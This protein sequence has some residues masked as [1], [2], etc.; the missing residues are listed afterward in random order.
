M[1]F[2]IKE[3]WEV[4]FFQIPFYFAEPYF[5]FFGFWAAF[6]IAVGV[7]RLLLKKCKGVW[8]RWSFA[9]VTLVGLV[10]GE[11]LVR[12]I[13]GWDRILYLVLYGLFLTFALGISVAALLQCFRKRK[14]V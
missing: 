8:G 11:V 2:A 10:A 5:L 9:G 3:L 4:G 13:T 6:F 14:A 12:I 7:Q 1:T